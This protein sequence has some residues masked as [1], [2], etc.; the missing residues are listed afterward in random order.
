MGVRAKG[1]TMQISGSTIIRLAG[2]RIVESWT[3]ADFL[4]MFQQLGI[5]PPLGGGWS[6]VIPTLPFGSRRNTDIGEGR[7]S[8]A[9]V[10][11][12]PSLVLHHTRDGLFSEQE[13]H[14]ENGKGACA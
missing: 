14:E 9:S 3:H 6:A 11:I 4:G 7:Y 8:T 1:K 2:G 5:I 10:I 12:A 13:Q